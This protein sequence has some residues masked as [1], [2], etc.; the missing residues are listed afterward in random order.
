MIWSYLMGY[1]FGYVGYDSSLNTLYYQL[2]IFVSLVAV[3][4]VAAWR[5]LNKNSDESEIMKTDTE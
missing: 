5:V 2:A 1:G 4:L 3:L